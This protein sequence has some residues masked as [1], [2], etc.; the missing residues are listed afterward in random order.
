MLVIIL[1]ILFYYS[2]LVT[3]CNIPN[4]C[5]NT[6]QQISSI[7][8]TDTAVLK[9]KTLQTINN[10]RDNLVTRIGL[11]LFF[12]AVVVNLIASNMFLYPSHQV[13]TSYP[14]H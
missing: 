5:D 7:I 11:D 2:N 6:S 3:T 12:T 10:S 14:S 13:L 4:V 9:T 8:D 1:T